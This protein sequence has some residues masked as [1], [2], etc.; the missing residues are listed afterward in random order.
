LPCPLIFQ[1]SPVNAKPLHL[2]GGEIVFDKVGFQYEERDPLLKDLSI[3]IPQ[4]SRV[5]IVGPSGCGKSTLF[6]LLYRF[7]DPSSGR[8]LIDNQD[9]KNVDLLSLRKS[10]GVVPQ[11]ASLFNETLYY[12]IA[13]GNLNASEAEVISAAKSAQ[14]HDAILHMPNG[15]NTLVGERGLKLSGGEKQRVSIARMLLKN[16][17]IVVFDEA[18]SAL[19]SQTESDIMS[20]LKRLTSGKTTILIA[21]RLSTISD[22]DKIFVLNEGRLWEQGTHES[23]LGIQN[24]IYANMWTKQHAS[25]AH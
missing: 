17:G 5:A 18:T 16:P 15:Y 3:E 24:G 25:D 1:K 11:D 8:L 9:I 6:R 23:L 10:I 7:Y 4:G 19:D 21:H 12:N 14:I 13:Y 20:N 22:C 2:K